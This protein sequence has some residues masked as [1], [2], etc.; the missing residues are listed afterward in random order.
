M[1]KSRSILTTMVPA[2][3]A[4]RCER[5]GGRCA[6]GVLASPQ[7]AAAV[8]PPQGVASAARTQGVKEYEE[9]KPIVRRSPSPP[10]RSDTP[11]SR[12]A[13]GSLL[14]ERDPPPAMLSCRGSGAVAGEG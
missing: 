6:E 2:A 13:A 8:S 3:R 12:V 14:G 5:R 1:R 9:Q 7:G 11:C 10:K 4:S